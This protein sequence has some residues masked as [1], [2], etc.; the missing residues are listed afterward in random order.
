MVEVYHAMVDVLHDPIGTSPAGES[1]NDVLID[2]VHQI[3]LR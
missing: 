1:A 3:G 2:V